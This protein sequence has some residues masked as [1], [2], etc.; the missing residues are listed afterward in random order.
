MDEKNIEVGRIIELLV[1]KFGSK[2]K[3]AEKLGV[4]QSNLDK[5]LKAMSTKTKIK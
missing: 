4:N 2:V 3:A 1:R 5:T